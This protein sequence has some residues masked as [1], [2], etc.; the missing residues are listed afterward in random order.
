MRTGSLLNLKERLDTLDDRS[1]NI[2]ESIAHL[3]RWYGKLNPQLDKNWCDAATLTPYVVE[4]GANDWG[5]E[6]KL[7]GEDDILEEVGNT[8]VAGVLSVF[9]PI[10]NTSG[11]A[12]RLQF[13]WGTG[14]MAEGVASKQYIELMYMKAAN[15]AV[16]TPRN[17][18]GPIIPF[19]IDGLPVKL[20][21]RHWNATN[22][23]TISFFL[24]LSGNEVALVEPH[25]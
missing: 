22:A 9:L 4:S 7:F 18:W 1:S 23:A 6:E 11:T 13:V 17:L 19:F 5:A 24:G 20:W 21:A 12:S 3:V 25:G 15:N 10:A 16:F 2:C 14:T 8:L